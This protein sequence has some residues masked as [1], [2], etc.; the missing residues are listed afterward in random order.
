[1]LVLCI[2]SR[3][4]LKQHRTPDRPF[5]FGKVI[6]ALYNWVAVLFVAIT[7]VFFCFPGA[8][9]VN[10][11]HM[12]YV[13]AVIGIFV[14]LMSIY[15]LVY[16]KRFEGLRFDLIMGV[17]VGGREVSQVLVLNTAQK[18]EAEKL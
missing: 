12:N 8:L 17:A 10:G 7:S 9:P 1:M 16:G 3:S 11:N 2:R 4:I 6:G 5:Q 18:G 13:S 15:W 14:L